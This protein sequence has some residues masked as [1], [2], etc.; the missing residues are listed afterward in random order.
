MIKIRS[1]AGVGRVDLSDIAD[2]A[3]SNEMAKMY[4]IVKDWSG[5]YEGGVSISLVI[6]L[7]QIDVFNVCEKVGIFTYTRSSGEYNFLNL[8][9]NE[10]LTSVCAYALESKAHKSLFGR[11]TKVNSSANREWICQTTS[12][13]FRQ[14][15]SQTAFARIVAPTAEQAEKIFRRSPYVSSTWH[16]V[17]TEPFS[18]D[19]W[20]SLIELSNTPHR[21][22]ESAYTDAT[23]SIQ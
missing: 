16:D 9:T 22:G 5:E 21:Y 20:Q 15:A 19:A 11:A 6:S 8:T 18:D 2:K 13:S 7:N 3:M 14:T 17:V 10:T 4:R 1:A 23:S 12:A